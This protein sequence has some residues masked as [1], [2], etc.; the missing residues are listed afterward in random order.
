MAID[1]KIIDADGNVR[2]ATLVAGQPL[3]INPG[4]TVV[5]TPEA[6]VALAAAQDGDDLTLEA[7]GEQFRISGFFTA[8]PADAPPSALGYVDETGF[9]LITATSSFSPLSLTALSGEGYALAELQ[10][11]PESFAGAGNAARGAALRSVFPSVFEDGNSNGGGD[12]EGRSRFDGQGIEN[13]AGIVSNEDPVLATGQSFGVSEA[14]LVG[15]LVGLVTADDR[16][17]DA[18]A[19]S[20]IGGNEAGIFAINAAT[21]ALTIADPS[22]LDFETINQ[23]VLD[24]RVSDNQGGSDTESVT[25]NVSDVN[26]APLFTSPTSFQV[27]ENSIV[28]TVVGTL[29]AFDADMP[30]ND[31]RFFIVGGNEA[32]FF[33]L[34]AT[35][36]TLTIANTLGLDFETVTQFALEIQVTDNQGGIDTETVTVNVSDVNDAPLFTSPTSFQVAENSIA[37]TVVGTLTASDTDTPLGNLTFSIVGGNESGVFAINAATGVLSIADPSGLDFESLTQITL[38]VQVSDNQGGIDA[39]TV[40]INVTDVNDAPQFTSPTS[41][42]VT[43]NSMVGAAVGTLTAT[44]V[45]TPVGN[46]RFS[47]VGGSGASAFTVDAVTG[48]ISVADNTLLDREARAELT[49]QVQVD[50]NGAPNQSTVQNVTV[51]IGPVDEFVPVVAGAGPFSVAENT[52][53]VGIITATDADLPGDALTYSIVPGGDGVLFSIDAATGVLRF[54]NPPD[55]EMAGDIGGDNVYDITVAATSDGVNFGTAPVQ[56]TVTNVNEAPVVGAPGAPLAAT[57]DVVLALHG[58]G[59]TVADVDA[60]PAAI[61]TATLAVAQGTINVTVGDSGTAV[62]GGNG[63]ASVTVTGTQS[64]LDALLTGAG[65]GLID[66]ST[67]QA[68]AASTNFTVTVNDGG[69]SGTDPGLSGGPADEEGSNST[70][71]NITAVN[72]NPTLVLDADNSSGAGLPDYTTGFAVGGVP[73]AILDGDFALN[74]IDSPTLASITIAVTNPLNGGDDVLA[75]VGSGAVDQVVFAVG[76]ANTLTLSASGGSASIADFRAALASV[77]YVNNASPMAADTTQRVITF[78]VDDGAGANN[79][80]AVATAFVGVST[81]PVVD[82]DTAGAGNNFANTF[83]EDVGGGAFGSGLIAIHNLNNV[84]VTDLD[85]DPLDRMTVTIRA[86][87]FQLGADVLSATGDVGGA[88]MVFYNAATGVLL[89]TASGGSAPAASFQTVLN[90]VRFNNTS[91]TPSEVAR[92]IDVVVR[93]DQGVSSDSVPGGLATATITVQA[94]NDAPVVTAPGAAQNVQEGV[95]LNLHGAGFTVTDV[96]AGVGTLTANLSVGEGTVTVGAGT[97]GVGI[98]NNGTANVTVTGTAAQI[99]NLL[100]G[101]SGGTVVYLNNNDVPA[102]TTTFTV[103]VND[104]GN[105]GV[106]PG[107]SGD[108]SSEAGSNNVLINIEARNDAPVITALNGG[109]TFV[110]SAGPVVIDADVAVADAELAALNGG[111]GN[112]QGASL[113]LA[114]QGGTNTDDSF[115]F[116]TG[117]ASFAVNGA[118]LEDLGGNQF[119]TFTNVGGTLTITFTSAAATATTALVNDVLQRVTYNNVS[120]GPPSSVA[121]DYLFS[122]GNTGPG[123]AQGTGLAP[124]QATGTATLS[125]IAVND[126]PVLVV[127]AGPVLFAESGPA[128]VLDGAAVVS[129]PELDA[130]NANNGNYAGATLTIARNGGANADDVFSGTG[131][132][133]AALTQGG[134]FAIGATTVGTVTTNSGGTLLLT[135]NANATSALV[136]SVLQQIGYS[137]ANNNPPASVTIDWSFN[138]GNAGAQGSGGALADTGSVTVNITTAND[139]PVFTNLGGAVGFTE[140]GAAVVLDSNALL[141]DPELDAT[142]WSGATLQLS[143]NGGANADDVFSGTGTLSATLTQGGTFA[144]GATTVGTVTTNSGGTLLLTFNGNA[145]AA[146]VDSVLQQIAYSNTNDNPP[147]SVQIDYLVNDQNLGAQGAGGALTDSGSVTVNITATNDAPVF[148]GL[149]GAVGFTEDGAAVVLDNDATLSDP[150]LDATNWSGATLRLVRNGGANADDVFSGTGTLTGTLTQ[151]ATFAIGATTVGTVTTN[152]GGTLLLTF[153]ANATAALVDSVLQQ[154][155][156]SNTSNTPPASVQIDYL[157]NDQ[158]AGAQGAGGALTGSGSVTVNLTSNNDAPVNVL[159]STMQPAETGVNLVFNTMN[160]NQISITD[161]DAGGLNVNVQLTTSAGG[162][163]FTLSGVAGLTGDTDG[164]DGTL[165]ITGT[166]VAV[167]AALDGLIYNTSTAGAQ[168]LTVTTSDLGNTGTLGGVQTDID[169][170]T[171]T[172][173]DRPDVVL[174]DGAGVAN[175]TVAED[176]FLTF[177]F[178][179][180]VG[181]GNGFQVSDL[182]DT[183]LT[184]DL[185]V[186]NGTLTPNGL[187]GLGGSADTDGSDG[188]LSLTGTIASLNTALDGLQYRGNLNYFG[189]DTLTITATDDTPLSSME[190]INLTVTSVNDAP[191]F[192]NLGGAVGFTED[193]TAVVL[194]NNALLSDVELDVANNWSGATLRLL[195]NGGAN[196]DDVFSGTGTLTATLTQGGTFAISGTTVGTVTTNSGGTLLLTFN[197]NATAALVDNVLQQIAYSNTN[198]NPPASVQIDYLVNDQNAGAQGAGGALTGSGSVTVNITANNDAPAFTNLGGAA[199][200]TED[201]AAVVLDSNALLSDPELDATNW[202]GATLQLSRNGGAN[203][204]DVFS[205]TGTLTGTL[206]QGGTFAIGATTV[207]TV[208]TN[209]GG[210]LLLTFDANATAAL[211]DSVLQQIAYSNTNNN[212][213]ASVQI[214]YL[215]NDQNAGAQ[216]IGGAL[217]GTGSVTVNI[218]AN[219]DAPVFTGLGGAVGFTEDGVAVVLDND[220]TLSDP[221]LDG[222]NWSGATLRLVRNGGANADDV[223]SGSGTLSATLTQGGTFAIGATTVGTVTTNSGGTLL[224]TFNANATA[225]LVDSVL[226]QIAYRNTS[227]TPPA[228]VQIDYLVNDQNAG[229]QGAGGALTGTGSVTVNIT[230][231]NDAPVFTNLGGAVGFTENGAAVVLDSN[232]LL[233]DPELDVTNWSGA[234]LQLSRNGGANADD[235]FSGTGTLT[236]TLTQGGTFA[237]GATTVGTV[238]TNSGGTLLLTFNGNATAALVDSVLQQIAY[239]NTND[240]PPASVQIDYLV[241]DQNLGAQGAGGALTD[242][243]SVTVN[244]TATNDAPVFTGLGG[245]VGFTEDGA[246]VVLDN[247]ATLSDPELDATNWSGATLRLVRN[248]GANADDVFSGTGTLTGTLTQGATFAIGATTVGTVTTNS[249]GTLLL[250]FNANATAALVDSVLQQIGYSNTSN[251]PPASVQIDYL[252]ND[253]NAGAQGAGGALTGSGSVTVNLTSNNDAPVNV[254]QSTMQPAETG[255]NLVFNTMNTNQISITDVDAGGLNVNV[256]LTT[257][258]GGGTFTLSGV[259]GL[260]GDTDGSDGT[261]NITGTLVAVNAALDGLI[262][263]TST[264]GAQTLTVTTSDLGNTGT[265]GGVQT[266]ID[267]VTVTASDRPDVVLDD[268]AGVA[269]QTVAEDTFLTFDFDAGVGVGNGFQVSDLDDT[270]LTVDLTVTNGTLTPNGLVGLGGSAD[271][272]GSDGTLSLTGTIAS[273]NTALDGLQYRGNLNY[274]GGDTLTITATDDTPLSSME[275]INLTVTSVNDA[276]VFTNLG[277]AVGF[278]EDGTAV[279]LDNNALL[280]DVELDVANNWSGATLRL[281]RNGGANADD[282]FSGTGTLTATLTQGGTFAIS[283]TTVGTVTTNSGGTLLLTFNGNATAALVDNVLQQ[284]AYSNTNNNPPASVQIDYLVNDQNGGAQGAGGALTGTGSVTVNITA[285][286]DAPAFTNLGG[287]VGFTEDGAA[288]VLDSNAL[289]SDPELDATNWS[290]ATLRLVRNGGANAD[291]V[292][293]GTGTLT[294]TLTQ[295]GTFA[296]GATT[297]GTVTTNSGGTLLL[298]F[299]ANATAA[300][301]D[302]VLQ[303]IAYSNTNNNP[304]ASVQIDYLVNDQ[305]GGAQG[306]GGALTGT[307]SVTV[308]ITANN[309]APVFTGLGGAVGFT[310]DGVAVVLDN[311]ATLSDPE[312]D[313][314]NWSGATLRLVRNGGANADDVFSGSGTLSAALT[315]GGTFAIGATTVGTVTT[316]SGGTLLLTFNGNATAALVDSVLQ[317]IAYRNTSNTPPASVQIDYLVNDQNAGAQGAGGAL[318]GTGSVTVNITANNDAPTFTNLGGAVGFTENGAAVVLDSDALLSDP[319]L[320]ATNWSGATLQL[321]RNGGA[322]ADD[323]FSGTGTLTGTLTQGGTF[324]IGATTVGTVTTNSGGTLLLTFNGN[325]TAALVDSVLQQIAYSNTNNNPPGS[326]QI[327][328]LVNDQNL[329]AQGAGGALTDSGSVTVNITA[330]NDAPVFTG[331]GGAVGFTEDGAAVVLDGDATLSDPELDATNWSGATLRLVRNGGANADDVFSGSGTLSAALTQGATFAIGATTVGTVTTNSG[332][333]LLLTFNANATAALVDSVLQQIGY[334]NTSNTPPA[335]VQIDYLVND[336]NGGAQGAGGALTG[337][338]SVTV[339]L[340]SNNDAPVNVLQSTMQSAE[341]S[342]NLVFN[343]MNTNQISITDVDAGGLNVNVQLTTSAGGGTFTLSGVAGL[344]GDTDGSDGTLNI[345]GTLV[346]VNA[347]L[348][349]LIY[350]TSTAGAQTLTVTTSDLGNTGTLGGVQTDIDVVTVTAS[351]RPDVVLDDGAGVANQTVAEDTFLTF[352]FDAGVGVGNGFQVS[353]LDDTTLTVDLTVTNGTLT[354]NGLVGLGGSAD[355]DG[356]DGTLS[357]TGTIASLNTALDGLQYRGNLNYFGGDTLTITATDDTP[358][359]SMETI[360]LTVTSV[361]DAPVFTNLGG[362]V[363]FTEDGTAV[364]LDNNALLSDVELDVA[365]N[366]SGATLRLL[367]NGGANA[368]DVFS[369]TGTLTGTLTQGGTFAIG[370]TTVGT[371]TTNSGGTLLLTFNAN[372]TAALV[373]SVLQQIAYSNTNNNPPASVQIDYLVNDQNGGAQGAGG[374]LTG[375]GSVTVNITANNDAPAFTNLGGAVGFTEDGA[376][377]VLDSNALLSDPELDATNW[378]GA[379]LR[380]VRNGG[381][382]A[383]DVFSGTGTLTGTLTQGGT[384]AIGATTVGTVTTNSGGTLLLTFDANATAALVDSVLQ[385]IAYSN[386][387]N[388]PPASVQIDYLVNDQNGGAQ[389]IG[390]ALTGTGSVTVNITANNDAP[391]FTGLDATPGFTEDGVAVALDNNATLSDPELDATNWSGATLRLVRNGGANADDVFSGSGTLSAVLTQGGTFAISGTTVGTVTTNSGGTLLLTFNANATAALVDSVLQQIAYRN[392]NNNP[393]ASVQI[394][395]LVNDQNAGAQGAGGALTGTGSVTVNITANND[396]PVFTNLG[397]AVGFTEDG[398]AVVLDSNA[399][400]SDPEL[401]VTN[402]SGA[403]LQLS[404]NG[405]ANADDVFSGTGTLTGTLTQG[406]TFAIG[407]TTVGTVTTNSGGTLLLTF[408]ANATAALV[409]SVLQQIAYSNTNNNPPGSVQIDYLVNDQNAGAQGIGGARTGT[410]SVTVNI[411]ANNDAPVF[412]GLDA[413]PGFTEDGAAVALDSNATLSDPELDATNWSGA[414]LRLVRNGGANADDVFSGTGTLSAAL[415]QG[416]TFAIGATT[417]GTVTTNSGGTLLLTFNANATAA[418]VDS[419]L[420]QIGYRNTSNTPPASVQIDF[421]VNDQNAG[422]QGAGGAKTG[423]G[424]VTVTITEVNDAPVVMSPPSIGAVS[425]PINLI[426]QI[427]VSD[428]DAGNEDL[429]L[430]LSSNQGG[431]TIDVTVIPP[432]LVVTNNNS[433][434]VTLEGTLTELTTA[435]SNNIFYGFSGSSTITVTLN[436]QNVGGGALSDVEVINVNINTPP[437]ITNMTGTLSYIEDEVARIIDQGTPAGVTDPDSA[438]FDTGTLTVSITSGGTPTEDVIGIRNQGVGAG[439][440]GVSG[441]NVSFSNVVFGTFTG[442]SGGSNL[443]VT[444]D[445]DASPAAVTALLQNLIYTNTNTGNPSTTARTLEF[446]VTDGDGGTSATATMTV[447]VAARNDAPLL[448]NTDTPV[449]TAVDENA[450]APA[451]TIASVGGTL[452]STLVDL[453]PPVGGLDNVTDPDG[454]SLTG[455]AITALNGANGTWWFTANNGATAWTQITVGAISE[456]NALLLA[457]DANTGIFFRP[458]AAFNGTVTNAITFRAWDQTFGTA[459]TT[460]NTAGANNGGTTAFSTAIDTANVTVNAAGGGVTAQIDLGTLN[461]TAG[462]KITGVVGNSSQTF[463]DLLGGSVSF[464]GDVNGD[465]FADLIIGATNA[466]APADSIGNNRGEAYLFLGADT[467]TLNTRANGTTGFSVASLNGTNGITLLGPSGNDHA[468]ERVGAGGDVDGDGLSDILIG[469][470]DISG[471][472]EAY[473]LFGDSTTD[474]GALNNLALNSLFGGT[475]NNSDGKADGVIFDGIA[476]NGEATSA[477]VIGD[478]DND[479]IDD[480]LVGSGGHDGAGTNAGAAYLIYGNSPAAL[481]ALPNLGG[482]NAGIRNFAGGAA[483]ARLGAEVSGIGDVN[484]DGIDDFAISA[485]NSSSSG[486]TYIIFGASR[487]ALSA[488]PALDSLNGSNGGFILSESGSTQFGASV[489]ALGDFNGDGIDDFIVGAGG[490]FGTAYVVFGRSG[491]NPF[492]GNLTTAQL[493]GTNSATF[494]SNGFSMFGTGLGVGAAGAGDINGDGLADIV[495]GAG[496]VNNAYIIFGTTTPADLLSVPNFFVS[497]GQ[498]NLFVDLS[499]GSDIGGSGAISHGYQLL[500]G[501]TLHGR[502]VLLAG[503]NFS[504]AGVA[505]D[506]AGDINNDGFDDVVIGANTATVG[507]ELNAGTAFVVY[508][509]NF[510]GGAPCVMATA[511]TDGEVLI[512]GADIDTLSSGTQSGVVMLAGAGNDILRVNG[513]EGRVNGGGGIDV[514]TPSQADIPLDFDALVSHKNYTGIEQIQLNSMGDNLLRIGLQD[515]LEMS[516]SLNEIL[517]TGDAG[518]DSIEIASAGWVRTVAAESRDVLIDA[519][520][521]T[522]SLSFDSYTLATSNVNLLVQSDLSQVII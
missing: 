122:D 269:N 376:A 439:Q 26:D 308:N 367:R 321:S 8:A 69:A 420:Q 252:V 460:T 133:S 509:Q 452:I 366:W 125:V 238:T 364:V 358:L 463:A 32:G 140:N 141:S 159:Q 249:G 207:G 266:D 406:G 108:G 264:A 291:D 505:V 53:A 63:S 38:Q 220:A 40:T 240:N 436:D 50:D 437:T 205:G 408:N 134:T 451:G 2:E 212:P 382:N 286:N 344:T 36:G 210:T 100:I 78:T 197:G 429:L 147:A 95:G 490:G 223:F 467:A 415:T 190:T 329:G 345:T 340:T 518:N 298:T 227:N 136:D 395:Y 232:A 1:V 394:D 172:A 72:D 416:G 511:T 89:I 510:G 6:A 328:Y 485:P 336:Q 496:N 234:T 363:G 522:E 435:L 399:L 113:I 217:T 387:N 233:S 262:Y 514:L 279:V 484:N 166:L 186:T 362:A 383:D 82:L 307:G 432:G 163:T 73:V 144:I 228:S 300:L 365:N 453:N 239:S 58:Q 85:M 173:S 241:N 45:D 71:I 24:V 405:G 280:S 152:S 515:V 215:V 464:A 55:A 107:L 422:A 466:E 448:D 42:L 312:L 352:D 357:L 331:L 35:T 13:A 359:S 182:D 377:V 278:T 287:A 84:L 101:A 62:I 374:A 52:T 333:T 284:I 112:F 332:G 195:R 479:G 123:F 160:T 121:L 156:Y 480:I 4:E 258:A 486:K 151:G 120:N 517:V 501:G 441:A 472:S 338:G 425:S 289:L 91:D 337:S 49:L 277:G 276:P 158:N 66:Y 94:A 455:I 203:A 410:G 48:A 114:R 161:V 117:G 93:D 325:A 118:A 167:N 216:G 351:D 304:P 283:G 386:T 271:T 444:F 370:A 130:L 155:G 54:L 397:G 165:N 396:A 474:L 339:N 176:T 506:G 43:E 404:R 323:V 419:V 56:I 371:V 302:S 317:Q 127:N 236:G 12:D 413:T 191:V 326:V 483:N 235:V 247:D 18:L 180:G 290:G 28:G 272:D 65:T 503:P 261:L 315:Q 154:I 380:L 295:G 189:G 104:G 347:A 143:R 126:A 128:I 476:I 25:I 313:G 22:R 245:A 76:A 129:D 268:G 7:D 297:V 427:M 309:D 47:I 498:N 83:T 430:T 447:S 244:I 398:A 41:F 388:N 248:G 57:E 181:V 213:P 368:D 39:E 246:A 86:G 74:D 177:D 426:N 310:E 60:G 348:D 401:D 489:S 164:S 33:A 465:G 281:L 497:V 456:S 469:E 19:F 421:L 70:T 274:F 440:I 481:T 188:T 153:N 369:G 230:A 174:D 31:L 385:Q 442:G 34:N 301:V 30:P 37:G 389:G 16:D 461:G 255:V 411:T 187:V 27:A 185:T 282:V 478:V 335:S 67:V 507:L 88:D 204:D 92:L 265:L 342:V 288:V 226:Q 200:F 521:L 46:L 334:S 184:V 116:N 194:D 384:F 424:S 3:A 428:P 378:S 493:G 482:V 193:G 183:T 90:S 513:N 322:N 124:G 391:V 512:G 412:T 229:A 97:T 433:Q 192:T 327:D 392:T 196:A 306:I 17:G 9:H 142:N 318:T 492:A 138:D 324:A 103:T 132:L 354:P 170:V 77:T 157:V 305:N 221:E 20:I 475:D 178:D 135:F 468:G 59:F 353:D 214:D 414:T 44:D 488:L 21:G 79:L 361:N 303:Q 459:T 251:T 431:A 320:D 355:T 150:E 445:P 61:L 5:L 110:E 508:G 29:T 487:A 450:A 400:L 457:A 296:I 250:T 11:L 381:A 80:S 292:F 145:T 491:V 519:T 218:T 23:F 243:G 149:G 68:P 407:A 500:P 375:T 131:T 314:T 346:A 208:T 495:V 199:G 372:A 15:D 273:L 242:S 139:A 257:S 267:V 224:L 225:A 473:L 499:D 99:N 454:S 343:T 458:N 253:Q 349:G 285:N 146:L 520:G 169:V 294:G 379:T 316:N 206:T 402:W 393:P 494:I 106:D 98:V 256:Q 51:Q 202:S 64:Q 75:G 231:N 360:N 237:I 409:D 449:M 356:S 171:V 179:A 417:V 403:T 137:N 102:A 434:T 477:R 350:N 373:D 222:T 341:T 105:F 260:T 119:A 516:G 263:N 201:G 175:Q 87:T 299:N 443:V 198:N 418:L 115:G 81:P 10:G 96:D 446:V 162:G 109:G 319:E 14:A 254:L 259:A 219:N 275:T 502:G 211:V 209:S 423:T 293:S 438:N 390:G 148:T 270:T 111:L 168:T 311:D 462:L 471:E 504:S 470:N 330:T